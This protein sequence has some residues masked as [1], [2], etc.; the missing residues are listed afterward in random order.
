MVRSA[1]AVREGPWRRMG[2][3]SVGAGEG[4]VLQSVGAEQMK[5]QGLSC[6]TA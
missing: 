3:V 4:V 6:A 5:V 1:C 2:K